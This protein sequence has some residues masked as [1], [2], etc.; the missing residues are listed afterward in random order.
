MRWV[1]WLL[2]GVASVAVFGCEGQ[3]GDPAVCTREAAADAGSVDERCAADQRDV[4]DVFSYEGCEGAV[5]S[6][7]CGRLAQEL[8]QCLKALSPVCVEAIGDPR[9]AA[10]AAIAATVC[11][12]QLDAWDNCFANGDV[13]DDGDSD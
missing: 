2:I 4:I 7:Y 3:A 11:R 13:A 5:G 8:V 1:E 12:E 6:F 9:E 10:R